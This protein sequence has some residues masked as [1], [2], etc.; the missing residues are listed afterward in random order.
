M[1]FHTKIK[2]I[3][4]GELEIVLPWSS[5]IGALSLLVGGFKLSMQPHAVATSYSHSYFSN[6]KFA[7]MILLLP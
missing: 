6:A 7:G 2:K 3:A 1:Y 5:S 4:S